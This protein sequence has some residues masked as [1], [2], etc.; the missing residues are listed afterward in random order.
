MFPL[1]DI[2]TTW[3]I[4][5]QY[6]SS[7]LPLNISSTLTINR[8]LEVLGFIKYNTKSFKSAIVSV[9]TLYFPLVKPL[10]E[11][12]VVVWHTFISKYAVLKKMLSLFVF[13]SSFIRL[14][15]SIL[16]SSLTT[17]WSR[18]FEADQRFINSLL[19]LCRYLDPDLLERASFFLQKVR[20]TFPLIVSVTRLLSLSTLTPPRRYCHNHSLLHMLRTYIYSR[21]L[22]L[23]I[24]F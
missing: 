22:L 13:Y 6:Y 10:L 2:H 14:L 15:F 16:F 17:T 3:V 19:N 11:Y 24:F 20:L 8:E 5:L 18:H 1:E 4:H 7:V 9:G 23:F 21:F 12:G